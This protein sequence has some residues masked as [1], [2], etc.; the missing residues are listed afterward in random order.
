MAVPGESAYIYGLHDRGGERLMLANGQARG[1]VLVTEKLGA[2]PNDQGGGYYQDL[3]DQGFGVLVRLNHA[4]GSDGTIPHPGKYQD[5]AQRVANFVRH[6]SGAHIWIIGNEMNLEREQPRRPGTG[7]PEPITPRQYAD[8]YRLCREAIHRLPGHQNDQVIVGAIG[9]WN[10]ETYYDADPQGKYSANK[11]PNGPQAFWG[12]FI[13]YLRDILLAIGAENCDGVAIHAYSHGYQPQL[14]FNNEKMTTPPEFSKYFYNFRTYR[15]QMNAIPYLFK[16]LPVY[17]TEANGDQDPGGV[18]WPDVNSGWVQNAYREINDWNQA[19]NQQI[20]CMVLYRW[21]RDDEWY[22]EGKLGVQKDFSEAI[23]MDYQWDP[24]VAA[25]MATTQYDYRTRFFNHNTPTSVPPAQ[26]L[27]VNITVQ[28]VGRLT[29]TSG[30]SNPFRLGFQW[31]NT[32]GQMVAFSPEFDFHNPLPADTP[33]GETVTLLARLRT[34]DTPGTYHLRWDMLHEQVSWFTSQGDAGLLVSPVTVSPGVQIGPTVS[35]Q[36]QD[37]SA[38]LAGFPASQY[39]RRARTAIRRIILHHTA[40]PPNVSVQRIAEYQV[41]N[42]GL[43][44]ITYHYCVTDQ[45]Q[46]YQTQPLEVVSSHAG[47]FSNDSIGV[48]LIGNFTDTT[49]PQQQLD[50]AAALLAQ[51]VTEFGITVDQIV[52]YS[53]LVKTGSPGATWPTWKGPLLQQVSNL[54]AGGGPVITPTPTPTPTPTAKPIEHYLLLWHRGPGNW[55]EWDLRGAMDYIEKFAPTIGFS[56]E[57]AKL[58]RYVTIVGGT[59]GVPAD[60]EQTLLAAGC[61]VERLAG[62]TETDTRRLLEELAAQ[63]K[64]F[65]TLQ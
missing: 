16:H 14:V 20:R 11:I 61:Q 65:K 41:N 59:G 28:N 45:G 24:S 22:I 63:G 7:Q 43:P 60:A 42:R 64:R 37:V 31:Y 26:T 44:G 10:A 23:K 34:P 15:D 52:G 17:L 48:C 56:L 33:P 29:W 49:P 5:F 25:G 8:C 40:T 12:D 30:G 50:A 47:N 57:E 62:P 9:P 35:A 6:S 2:N 1:W 58:A 53:D 54:M 4:Y 27:S 51:L 21:S 46:I 55:A 13:K 32:A 19:G 39:P 38:Q 18:R 36:I 3:T